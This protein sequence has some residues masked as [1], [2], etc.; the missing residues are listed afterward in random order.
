[1]SEERLKNWKLILTNFNKHD[2]RSKKTKYLEIYNCL[3][4][5]LYLPDFKYLSY[6]IINKY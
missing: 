3:S 4:E 1:M 5:E 6:E 2:G